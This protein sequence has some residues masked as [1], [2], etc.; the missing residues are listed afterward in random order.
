MKVKRFLTVVSFSALISL[1]VAIAMPRNIFNVS[2]ALFIMLII[3]HRATVNKY[4]R[5]MVV[6][7]ISILIAI[8]YLNIYNL[9]LSNK[10]SGFDG[11]GN[12]VRTGVVTSK[13]HQSSPI[14]YTIRLKNIN[15][16]RVNN[17]SVDVNTDDILRIGENVRLIGKYKSFTPNTNKSYYYSKSIFGRFSCDNIEILNTKTN[18]NKVISNIRYGLLNKI[19][20]IYN[21]NDVSLASAMG[22]GDKSLLNSNTVNQFS[23]TG[24]S[25]T[26]VVSGLHVGIIVVAVSWLLS[27][28][29]IK[30]IY[31]NIVTS[32]VVFL[33]MLIVGF[34]PS[35]IRAGVLSI[36]IL[37]GR[38]FILEIDN[39]TI[40][41]I[42]V[43]VTLLINPYSATNAS[44]LLSYSAYFGVLYRIQISTEKG[45]GYIAT[46][47]LMSFMAVV[48]TSPITAMLGMNI[49]LFSPIFNLIITPIISVVCVLSFFT[50]LLSFIPGIG[51]LTNMVLVPIN[52]FCIAIL[53]KF[54]EFVSDNFAFAMVDIG[55]ESIKFIIWV[56][57]IWYAVAAVQFSNDKISKFFVISVSLVSFLCYN[58][59]NKDVVTVCAFPNGSEPS[60]E[61]SYNG[62][63]YLVLSGN[64]NEKRL[65]YLVQ[66]QNISNFSQTILCCEKEQDTTC[67]SQYSD[68]VIILD[69]TDIFINDILKLKSD[70]SENSSEYTIDIE[71]V[72]ISFSYGDAEIGDSDFYFMGSD[73]PIKMESKNNYYF[74]NSYNDTQLSK[75][76]DMTELYN[77]FTIKI[78]NGK[79]RIIKDVKN[80][81][82]KL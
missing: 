42:I 54:T 38:S 46:T 67:L 37:I 82:Y 30:K 49:T 45:Y 57:V 74:Y 19:R 69:A 53:L 63:N 15:G 29:P 70:I 24:V 79:Y 23:F 7:F 5:E 56:F 40:L 31:K 61:I 18:L 60:F 21:F 20:E 17:F 47:L 41:A 36:S 27:W 26:L 59:M 22:L 14:R 64:I 62:D 75:Y 3:I 48:F 13:K 80:F 43:F 73:Q 50:P 6:S 71:G 4:T 65:S 66:N 52:E 39:F 78:K 9:S 58:Y 35:V 81:G 1:Y 12:T 10:I 2:L 55:Q 68:E 25:H 34:T 8:S 77:M 33:F 28:L 72:K 51:I 76:L 32:L 44:L 11:L 16:K